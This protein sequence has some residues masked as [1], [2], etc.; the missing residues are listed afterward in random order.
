MA[1]LVHLRNQ[2]VYLEDLLSK[3]AITLNALRDR[4]TRNER[5]L[6]ENSGPRSKRKKIQQNH[7]RT[8]RTIRA[9]ENEERILVDCLRVCRF[10]IRTLERIAFATYVPSTGAGYG[11]SASLSLIESE[12]A[13]ATTETE[14]DWNGWVNPG[15]VSP[16]YPR[17]RRT[18]LNDNVS[19]E[20]DLVD[21]MAVAKVPPAFPP[22]S[23]LDPP[24]PPPNSAT[25]QRLFPL[26]P[27]APSFE[28]S[29]RKEAEPSSRSEER[30]V[31]K[32]C[33]V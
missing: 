21:D 19:P 20:T 24:G 14:F 27:V 9:R 33:P 17:A 32:E 26:S 28:P 8:D 12:S 3:T 30:R 29:A 6:K 1:A 2:E 7:W 23:N 25:T 31:G 10:N 11:G 18:A 4:Q 15:D 16:F 5:A 13:T 22:R